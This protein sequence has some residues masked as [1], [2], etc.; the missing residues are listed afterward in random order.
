MEP[1]VARVAVGVQSGQS[2]RP[3]VERVVGS[4]RAASAG[5]IAVSAGAAGGDARL[6]VRVEADGGAM[7]ETRLSGFRWD[8]AGPAPERLRLLY[9]GDLVLFELPD[10]LPRARLVTDWIVEPDA[11]RAIAKIAG[12][13]VPVERVAV[14][15]REPGIERG[16][17]SAPAGSSASAYTAEIVRASATR[18]EIVTNA[19]GPAVLV[20]AD[21]DCPGWRAT[22]DGKPTPIVRANGLYR[23]VAVAGGAQR[24]VL[25]FAPRSYWIGSGAGVVALVATAILAARRRH[26]RRPAA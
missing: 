8:G 4:E 10:A 21:T 7:P 23:G 1:G 11:R 25:T 3:L 12:G 16:A 13:E 6:I 5:T 26:T 9:A 17:A 24:A 15:D 20:L 14:L 2:S 22:V 18:V 19:P